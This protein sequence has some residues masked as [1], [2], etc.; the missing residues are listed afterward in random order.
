MDIRFGSQSTIC[1]QE[2][3]KITVSCIAML[4]YEFIRRDILVPLN[5]CALEALPCFTHV[6]F[7]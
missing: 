1:H 6:A 5:V 2:T 4:K 7:L 3:H